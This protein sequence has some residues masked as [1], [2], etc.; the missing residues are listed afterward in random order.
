MS[1]ATE[2]SM[3]VESSSIEEDWGAATVELGTGED[4]EQGGEGERRLRYVASTPEMAHSDESSSEKDQ[5]DVIA[6]TVTIQEKIEGKQSRDVVA[7]GSKDASQLT[8]VQ[9]TGEDWDAEAEQ[10]PLPLAAEHTL[11]SR[12]QAPAWSVI[13]Y[14]EQCWVEGTQLQSTPEQVVSSTQQDPQGLKEQLTS[15]VVFDEDCWQESVVP[16]FVSIRS[17]KHKPLR[18]LKREDQYKYD[19]EIRTRWSEH[20]PL[21]PSRSSEGAMKDGGGDRSKKTDKKWKKK[22]KKKGKQG[23]EGDDR[24]VRFCPASQGE[25]KSTSGEAGEQISSSKDKEQLSSWKGKERWT[26]EREGGWD[27]SSNP[28]QSSKEDSSKRGFDGEGGYGDG[29]RRETQEF[30]GI[31]KWYMR[32]MGRWYE[33][34]AGKIGN[35]NQ[36]TDRA[37][38]ELS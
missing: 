25:T 23:Q 22:K 6:S 4:V 7:S 32:S 30:Y 26:R 17:V 24:H 16:D 36:V 33:Y 12:E 18:I 38:N 9:F 31:R 3:P 27:R 8:D 29:K 20:K 2:V 28:S 14:D 11:T 21:S 15:A 5:G 1:L 10:L 35:R 34:G 13:V 37:G 19:E